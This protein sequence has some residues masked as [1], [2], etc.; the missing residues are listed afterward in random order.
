M[1]TA[2]A[3]DWSLVTHAEL[4]RGLRGIRSCLERYRNGSIPF[5]LPFLLFFGR[6]L[7]MWTVCTISILNYLTFTALCFSHSNTHLV[8]IL[9]SHTPTRRDLYWEQHY[10]KLALP[11]REEDEI[12]DSGLSEYP[13]PEQIERLIDAGDCHVTLM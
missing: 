7:Y 3:L 4:D 2:A 9:L 12:F 1:D 10:T 13:L 8:H 5:A 6:I 11:G